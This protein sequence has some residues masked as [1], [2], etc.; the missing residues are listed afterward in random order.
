MSLPYPLVCALLG[1]VIGW[2]PILVHGPIA[3]RFDLLYMNG[4]VA[5]WAFYCARLSIGVFVGISV[6]PRQ[7]WVRGPLL[8]FALMLPV[9]LIALASPGCGVKCMSLNELTGAVVGT[10]VAGLARL[11][12]G[13]DHA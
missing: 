10:I 4:A 11:I 8:G 2:L 7:W 1:F 12:T 5:V 6:W 9:G 3:E 13:R